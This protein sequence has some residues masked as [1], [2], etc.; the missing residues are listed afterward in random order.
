MFVCLFHFSHYISYI[1]VRPLPDKPEKEITSEIQAIMRQ[2]GALA[3]GKTPWYVFQT[4]SLSD[5]DD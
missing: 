4:G 2:V 5:S 1:P 3:G